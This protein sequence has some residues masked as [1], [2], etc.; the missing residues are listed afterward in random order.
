MDREGIEPP[1]ARALTRY[2]Q[3]SVR[4]SLETSVS[5]YSNIKLV[6]NRVLSH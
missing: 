6:N 3:L 5:H 1:T 2:F 4:R